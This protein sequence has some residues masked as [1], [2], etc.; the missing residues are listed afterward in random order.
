MSKLVNDEIHLSKSQGLF[1]FVSAMHGGTWDQQLTGWCLGV[2]GVQQL[3]ADWCCRLNPLGCWWRDWLVLEPWS[4]LSFGLSFKK[5]ISTLSMQSSSNASLSLIGNGSFEDPHGKSVVDILE[6]VATS[7]SSALGKTG[8]RILVS[9]IYT[10][11]FFWTFLVAV[12][13]TL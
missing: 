8:S 11:V 2:S 3:E 13:F 10:N 12:S 5:S 7:Y 4:I 9:D 6:A 1:G